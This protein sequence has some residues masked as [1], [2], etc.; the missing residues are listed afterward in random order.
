[1]VTMM[2]IQGCLWTMVASTDSIEQQ[3]KQV[4]KPKEVHYLVDQPSS[5]H[6]QYAKCFVYH[7]FV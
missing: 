6:I 2:G 7:Y 3:V 5:G 4:V 1:M